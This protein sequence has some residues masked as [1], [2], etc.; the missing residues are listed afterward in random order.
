MSQPAL[1]VPYILAAAAPLLVVLYLMIGRNWGGSKAGPVGY[2]AA[3]VISVLVFGAD[4]ELILV[5]LGRS[6]LLALFVLYIVW[7]A[8]L[9]YHVVNDAGAIAVLRP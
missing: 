5:A 8:L 3:I 6:V 2:L 4:L 9:L 7:M 1:A